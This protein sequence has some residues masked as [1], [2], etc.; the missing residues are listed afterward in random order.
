MQQK[1]KAANERKSMQAG[2]KWA[3]YM[4]KIECTNEA[5]GPRR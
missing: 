2:A 1:Q 3:A 5:E 4:E